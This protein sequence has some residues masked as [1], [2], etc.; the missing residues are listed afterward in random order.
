MS[1]EGCSVTP[2]EMKLSSY[3]VAFNLKLHPHAL[4]VKEKEN[5]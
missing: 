4:E 5:S 3:F 1:V 2:L